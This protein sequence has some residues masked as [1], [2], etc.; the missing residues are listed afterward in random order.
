MKLLNGNEKKVLKE[1]VDEQKIP[2]I[3]NFKPQRQGMILDAAV[4]Y[5]E[6]KNHQLTKTPFQK[7]LLEMRSDIQ[8][9]SDSIDVKRGD[10]PLWMHPT[11]RIGGGYQMLK[12]TSFASID[13]RGAYHDLLDSPKGFDPSSQIQSLNGEFRIGLSKPKFK[14]DHL[15]VV[16]VISTSPLAEYF[17]K[18]SWNISF[19]WRTVFDQTCVDCGT[20]YLEGGPGVTLGSV[21]GKR[22]LMT[23]FANGFFHLSP[24]NKVGIQAGPSLHLNYLFDVSEHFRLHWENQFRY[25]FSGYPTWLGETFLEGQLDLTKNLALRMG[26]GWGTYQKKITT[27]LFLYF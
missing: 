6:I 17:S 27:S 11:L 15:Q 8:Y 4:D 2:L 23:F 18:P 20:I 3:N 21:Q 10:D 24:W 13:F 1:I 5:F 7:K 12:T 14:L 25:S 26:G 16:D 19:G 22:G 9:A